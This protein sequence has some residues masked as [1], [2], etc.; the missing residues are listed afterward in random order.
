MKPLTEEQKAARRKAVDKYQKANPDKV[1]A[2]REKRRLASQSRV[3]I[4]MAQVNATIK[5][6]DS[7]FDEED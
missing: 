7:N 3:A 1:K 4:A 2:S 5:K 6:M